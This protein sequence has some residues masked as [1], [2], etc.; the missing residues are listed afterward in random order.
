MRV[1]IGD[2]PALFPYQRIYRRLI[3]KAVVEATAVALQEI[4]EKGPER[5]L[6][7]SLGRMV[8]LAESDRAM[9]RLTADQ[10]AAIVDGTDQVLEFLPTEAVLESGTTSRNADPD[11][12]PKVGEPVFNCVGGAAKST[13]PPQR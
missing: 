4:E 2:E 10:T 7:N 11:T 6:D 1:L 12:T 13:M 5:G 8:V 3:R 9:G